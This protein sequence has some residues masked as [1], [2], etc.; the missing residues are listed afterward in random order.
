MALKYTARIF[1]DSVSAP[2]ADFVSLAE[3]TWNDM[4]NFKRTE[5]YGLGYATT[6]KRLLDVNF[7]LASYRSK[8]DFAIIKDFYDAMY[9]DPMAAMKF[10][11]YARDA[12][13]GAGERRYFRV[14]MAGIARHEP[15]LAEALL[16]LFAEYGR[17]DDILCLY[18]IDENLSK[19]VDHYIGSTL[20]DD[21][22]NARAGKPISLMAKW[23]PSLSTGDIVKRDIA[24]RLAKNLFENNWT[25]YRKFLAHLRNYLDV[26]ECKMSRREWEKIDYSKVPSIANL[27]YNKAFF[28]HDTERR[29][30]FIESL[31]KGETKV[32]ASVA[33]PHDIIHKMTNYR[34]VIRDSAEVAV[35]EE[36]WKA[37]PRDTSY[38]STLVVQDGSGSMEA[39]IGRGPNVHNTPSALVVAVALAIYFA[40]GC[41]GPYKNKY[42]TFSKRPKFINMQHCT[43]LSN[44]VQTAMA[45]NEVSNTNIEAVFE[46]LLATAVENRLS[47]E[48]LPSRVLIISDMEF[49][50]CA[51]N[52]N[53]RVFD[54]IQRK[55]SEAG[56]NVPA[57]VFWNVN[58]RTATIPVTT[59]SLG[60][61]LVSGFS[62]NSMKMVLTGKTDPYE[63]LMALLNTDRYAP[64]EE[65]I[66]TYSEKAPS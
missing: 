18:G 39:A 21:Y 11:F 40:E 35:L 45:Y 43:S 53:A 51:D 31:K 25:L 36:M 50:Q 41:E 6:G 3:N 33:F 14:V 28:K 44:K 29:L 63:A 61:T 62:P 52:A 58:S 5:N 8:N 30:A 60:V 47:Q 9:E 26:V 65:A 13:G 49:D 66:R 20:S 17:F 42:M 4:F 15:G 2:G 57:L 34:S 12:R 24:R 55:F 1:G 46:L 23:M 10:L 37:L 54:N 48:Q 16:P 22:Q 56:Y 59:N 7:K 64:V 19:A 38:G 32:N 27:K